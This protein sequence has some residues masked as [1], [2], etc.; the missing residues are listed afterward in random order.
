[1]AHSDM[2][3]DVLT[4]IR[5][6]IM[7]KKESVIVPASKMSSRILEILKDEGYIEHFKEQTSIGAEKTIKIYLK[8]SADKKPTLS[9]LKM[10]SRPGLR[11]YA[12]YTKMPSVLRGLGRA[13]VSTSQ[14]LMTD[15]Q[16]RE[17]KLGGEIIC[18]VW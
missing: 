2:V 7:A 5:N 11:V 15:K 18:Y 12:K 9:G 6:S 10:V 4:M 14:G 17:R 8:Y 1:M 16:A 13:I 3:A